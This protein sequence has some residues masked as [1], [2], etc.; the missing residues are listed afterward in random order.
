MVIKEDNSY[1]EMKGRTI[2]KWLNEQLENGDKVNSSGAKVTLE[3]IDYLNRK[4]KALEDKNALKD[5]YLK[6]LKQSK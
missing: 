6:K 1:N 2:L 5:E 3:Y 4:I